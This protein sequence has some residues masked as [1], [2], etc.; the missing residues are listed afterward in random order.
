LRT[1]T[2]IALSPVK[3]AIR[4][5]ITEVSISGMSPSRIS[6]PSMPEGNALKPAR[7]DVLRPSA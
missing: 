7:S 3:A 1:G 5:E 4:A 6:T 2:Q